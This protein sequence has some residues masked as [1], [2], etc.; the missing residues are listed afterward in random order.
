MF[1]SFH[2]DYDDI[3]DFAYFK[4]SRRLLRLRWYNLR[5]LKLRRLEQNL[6]STYPPECGP[7]AANF[8]SPDLREAFLFLPHSFSSFAHSRNK[9]SSHPPRQ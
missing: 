6:G 9:G 2:S 3:L 1:K 4:D 7:F 5:D 8:L